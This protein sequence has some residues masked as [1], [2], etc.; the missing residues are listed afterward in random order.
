MAIL[1]I[2]NQAGMAFSKFS[3]RKGGAES[4]SYTLS[5]SGYHMVPAHSNGR[6]V[7]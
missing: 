1:D 2:L 5:L 4:G 3:K 7:T 6:D